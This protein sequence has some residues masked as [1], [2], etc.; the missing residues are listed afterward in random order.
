MKNMGNGGRLMSKRLRAMLLGTN[1]AV[2]SDYVLSL[3]AV[4]GIIA[5]VLIEML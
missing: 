3:V 5:A 2:P 4:L 1:D